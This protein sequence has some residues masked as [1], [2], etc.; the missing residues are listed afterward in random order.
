MSLERKHEIEKQI[1]ALFRHVISD[2]EFDS[3]IQSIQDTLEM[4][5][6]LTEVFGKTEAII[7][8]VKEFNDTQ[9]VDRYKINIDKKSTLM[10]T[11][12]NI[13]KKIE[14]LNILKEHQARSSLSPKVVSPG[15]PGRRHPNPSRGYPHSPH[16]SSIITSPSAA[17]NA[18]IRH[19]S[20]SPAHAPP[21]VSPA[22]V[23]VN[24][25]SPNEQLGCFGRMCH[26]LKSRFSKNRVHPDH[27]R[28]GGKRKL[29]RRTRRTR[30]SRGRRSRLN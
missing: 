5:N 22:N 30:R 13:K 27:G 15:N 9:T 23:I 28:S 14:L 16:R 1:H 3:S 7:K 12:N 11:L 2:F 10:K 8:T 25:D 18:F 20:P 19:I 24:H 17:T 6:R 29:R 26:S 4:K 21:V